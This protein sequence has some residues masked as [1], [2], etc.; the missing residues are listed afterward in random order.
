[1]ANVLIGQDEGRKLN[2]LVLLPLS[3]EE[4]IQRRVVQHCEIRRVEAEQVH[5]CDVR[6]VTG[7]TSFCDQSLCK[8]VKED[9]QSF[10]QTNHQMLS[11]HFKGLD[12]K[13]P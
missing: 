4:E 8:F 10:V 6:R 7:D 3:L 13:V 11:I 5:E 2:K 1:M 9:R 12:V